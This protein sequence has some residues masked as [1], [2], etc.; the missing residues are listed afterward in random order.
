MM[1]LRAVSDPIEYSVAGIL[2]LIVAGMS[3]FVI[4]NIAWVS[5]C[6]SIFIMPC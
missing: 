2:L 5:L 4:P 3:T 1:E 6:L